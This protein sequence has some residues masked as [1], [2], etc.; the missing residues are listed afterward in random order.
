M[1]NLG[2]FLRF[3]ESIPHG[4]LEGRYLMGTIYEIREGENKILNL[5]D[6]DISEGFVQISKSADT[7][8][9]LFGINVRGH[10]R[11]LS[12]LLYELYTAL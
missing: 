5:N 11:C 2:D 4:W 6:F 1:K 10:P 8:M 12:A 3:A 9:L 7:M